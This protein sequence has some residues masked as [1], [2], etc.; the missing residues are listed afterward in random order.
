MNAHD[1]IEVD[2][3]IN[4]P[5]CFNYTLFRIISFQYN[6]TPLHYASEHG[7]SEVVQLLLSHGATVDMKD[8]VSSIDRIIQLCIFKIIISFQYNETP[9]YYASEHGHSEVVQ[10]LLSHGATV[11]M[12]DGRVSSIESV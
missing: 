8:E 3:S 10:L 1:V 2:S 11:D 5:Y 12:N 9:L 4:K 7:H 6:Q